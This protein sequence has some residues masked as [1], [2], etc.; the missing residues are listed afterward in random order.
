M[1]RRKIRYEAWVN[2]QRVFVKD[3]WLSPSDY[4]VLKML[5]MNVTEY[6]PGQPFEIY[7]IMKARM[8]KTG[9]EGIII[10]LKIAI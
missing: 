4:K 6:Y 8:P 10:P 7:K 5:R 9:E 3:T 1:K 2:G